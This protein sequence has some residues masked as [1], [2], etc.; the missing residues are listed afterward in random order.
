M[1][2]QYSNPYRGYYGQSEP[3]PQPYENHVPVKEQFKVLFTGLPAGLT[4]QDLYVR[5]PSSGGIDLHQLT[6]D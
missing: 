6:L 1:S 2:Y 4:S 5:I 3:P